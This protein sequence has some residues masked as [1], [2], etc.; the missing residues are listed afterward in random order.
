MA[1]GILLSGHSLG[2]PSFAGSEPSEHFG[3]ILAHPVA[4]GGL[5][6]GQEAGHP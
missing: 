5:P 6:S 2:Q 3:V 1:S 4:V